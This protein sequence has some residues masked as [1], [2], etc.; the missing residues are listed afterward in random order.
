MKS[1]DKMKKKFLKLDDSTKKL[2][3]ISGAFLLTA[4]VI[5]LFYVQ[6]NGENYNRIKKDRGNYLVYSK[7]EKKDDKYSK[8]VPDINIKSKEVDEANKDIDDFV[9]KYL[10]LDKT[11]ITY[12]YDL[13][14]TILSVVVKVVDCT[15]EYAPEVKYKT[16]NINLKTRKLISDEYLLDFFQ[17]DEEQVSAILEANFTNYYADLVNQGYY[18]KE[19]CDY[20]CFL[21][22]RG[23][24]NYL[25]D[26]HYYI[27]A[28]NL[29]AYRPFVYYSIFGDEEYF[30]EDSFKFLLVETE[31]NS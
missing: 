27:K 20:K 3:I 26:I 28:G 14:G 5:V 18:V 8:Y 1:I 24:S 4:L 2:I 11:I 22:Y 13:N 19:E 9:S 25:D 29:I 10:E 31:K 15:N 6:K 7:V 12:E 30:T 16:Y 17:T 21:N 23:I